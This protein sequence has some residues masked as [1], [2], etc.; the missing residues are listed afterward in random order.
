MKI[1]TK[2]ISLAVL[3]TFLLPTIHGDAYGINATDSEDLSAYI[4][5]F[6]ANP[7]VL[8]ISDPYDYANDY[9][10][11]PV[12]AKNS[13]RSQYRQ[14]IT[15]ND[16]Y[17]EFETVVQTQGNI[18]VPVYT[19]A[20][21]LTP[22]RIAGYISAAQLYPGVNIIGNPTEDYNCHSYA[23]YMEATYN[24]YWIVD[25]EIY[26]YDVHTVW[27]EDTE[28][29]QPGDIC[30]YLKDG[31]M[32]HSAIID[33]IEDET[34]ICRSK[35][36]PS[37][38]CEHPIGS[39][40]MAYLESGGVPSCYIMKI[41]PHEWVY[42]AS[43]AN[44]HTRT[45]TI[46]N[47]E[48]TLSCDY[49]YTYFYDDMHNASCK[50]CSN[51]YAGAFCS[52]T[53]TYNGDGTHTRSC[54]GCSNTY[55]DNCNLQYTNITN[56]RHSVACTVCDY[57][58]SSQ[59]CSVTYTSKGN[60]THT[61]TCSK[62]K[63]TYTGSCSIYY[64]YLSNNQHRGS[65]NKCSYT[66]TASCYYETTYCGNSTLGDVHKKQCQTCGH[67]SGSATTACTFQIKSIGNNQ[68]VNRC[69]ECLYVKSGPTACMFKSDGTCKFCGA[70]KDS[71]VINNLE[72]E[73]TA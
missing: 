61:A 3:S 63:N 43:G 33:R 16:I 30:V 14:S 35:W 39:V 41:T 68:H 47:I 45:C 1:T 9:A 13:A 73:E 70:R 32:V 54:N 12:S 36:G 53:T 72:Q 38:L 71:A 59:S 37:V 49:T 22:D 25:V 40:P 7:D 46:C 27:R 67:V 44:Q 29:P 5:E 34:I 66:H 42:E 65:C 62:C 6:P 48:E 50:Y 2:L 26:A 17:Y 69:T 60:K 51:G 52:F 18:D 31:Q 57:S 58:V 55:T 21:E 10:S 4:F 20:E 23:W 64:S 56:T 19:T 15:V 24:P 28:V 11:D 8:S